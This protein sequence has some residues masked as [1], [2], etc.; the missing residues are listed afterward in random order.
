MLTN[1]TLKLLTFICGHWEYA[2]YGFISIYDDDEKE[3][4]IKT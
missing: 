3:A 4:F 1:N 2:I